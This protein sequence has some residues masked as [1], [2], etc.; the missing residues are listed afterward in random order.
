MR[1][2]GRR[3]GLVKLHRRRIEC[4]QK[5]AHLRIGRIAAAIVL[6]RFCGI[7]DSR[8]IERALRLLVFDPHQ[9]RGGARL[10]ERL[11]NDQRDCLVVMLDFRTGQQFGYIEIA[12]AEL[13]GVLR[14]YDRQDA[15]G[16]P[17]SA[18]IH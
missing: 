1:L 5:V 16:C 17:G 10:F 8:K 18:Q 14:R 3:V 11:G 13:A 6:R 9:L 4:G 2:V 15:R 12:L 7:L